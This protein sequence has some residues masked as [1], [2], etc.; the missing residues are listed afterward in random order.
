MELLHRHQARTLAPFDAIQQWVSHETHRALPLRA[1]GG[2][3]RTIPRNFS[4]S[5]Y[6]TLALF[7]IV[8]SRP[9]YEPL[10]FRPERNFHLTTL[11]GPFLIFPPE[12]LE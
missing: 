4:F 3:S 5:P 8:D 7:E 12:D 11:T 10:F 2:A 6:L 9:S 1:T